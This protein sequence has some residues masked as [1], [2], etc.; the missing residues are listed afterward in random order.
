MEIAKTICG[1]CAQNDCGMDVFVEDGKIIKIKGMREHPYN[2]GVLC[3]KG[4]AAHQLISDPRRLKYPLKRLGKRGE[5]KWARISWDEALDTI[6]EKLTALKKEFGPEYLGLF[7]GAGPGWGGSWVYTQRFFHAFGSP[8]YATQAHLCFGPRAVTMATT[9]GGVPEADFDNAS[10]II[11]W[12]ANPPETSLPNYWRRISQ[13]QSRGAKLVVIDPRFTRA[14]SKADLFVSPRPGTDGALALG[15]AH[16]MIRD[17]LYD[18]AFVDCYTHGFKEYAELVQAYPPARVAQITGVPAETIETLARLYAETKPTALMVGNGVEQ[19]TNTMQTMRAI[20][21][22]PAITGNLGI[23]GGYVFTPMPPWSDMPLKEK[24]FKELIQ[25]A[26][27]KH[28]LFAGFSMIYPDLLDAI[29]TGEP[30]PL[31]AVICQGA[32]L[33]VLPEGNRY[34]ELIKSNLDLFVVHDLYMTSEAEIA[35]IVLPAASF[36]ECSRLRSTRFKADPYTQHVAVQNQV[37]ERVGESRPDEELFFDLARR[38]GL[39]DLFP[40]NDALEAAADAIKSLG[41]SVDDIAGNPGGKEWRYSEAEV[42]KFYEQKGFN[43]PTKKVELYNTT[44]EKNQYDPLPQYHEPAES[45]VSQPALS[46]EYPLTCLNG[47]KSVL[48]SHTQFRTIP[49]LNDLM[50][51]PWVELHPEKARELD[52]QDGDMVLMESPRGQVRLKARVTEGVSRPDMVFST[53]GWGQAYVG[54]PVTN[55]LTPSQPR[56]PISGSTSAHAF[57]CRIQKM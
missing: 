50:P 52:I 30:Y 53:Y 17:N 26:L 41:L 34:K 56:D 18:R 45:P 49:W 46:K 23:K 27:S 13:A 42:L 31:K 2:R 55:H 19:L 16:V 57:Q 35:D 25:K 15:L 32:P 4:L 29:E 28:K 10:L 3:P 20:Q 43:T 36:L 47:I 22:L 39:E 5:G 48:F 37:V 24:F 21:I 14:A 40:W 51:E 33:T 6:A 9:Y 7:R 12:A 8:N 1:L 54:G 11:L 38:L 44:F